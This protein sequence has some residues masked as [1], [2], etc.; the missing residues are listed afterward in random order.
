MNSDFENELKH[1][2]WQHFNIHA[3]DNS[4]GPVIHIEQAYLTC[5]PYLTYQDNTRLFG[6]DYTVNGETI[7]F[8]TDQISKDNFGRLLQ[9][10]APLYE[11]RHPLTKKK[12]I[13]LRKK[14]EEGQTSYIMAY[15]Q[16]VLDEIAPVE[17]QDKDFSK[18]RFTL[19]YPHCINP[20]KK[21]RRKKYIENNK[22]CVDSLFDRT[23]EQNIYFNLA[24][25]EM[26]R[27]IEK[28][29]FTP[30]EI[31]TNTIFE[32]P[33]EDLRFQNRQLSDINHAA[34][35]YNEILKQHRKGSTCF[36][37]IT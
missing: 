23:P 32:V 31:I 21:I 33:R 15:K 30:P 16:Y 37:Q 36:P 11:G 24:E 22:W 28:P 19:L 34:A 27:G 7:S 9:T 2:L 3:L 6:F 26:P 29:C 4:W 14:T 25:V 20:I 8:Q 5:T 12:S 17:V 13:R 35:L 1:I 18:D 10:A